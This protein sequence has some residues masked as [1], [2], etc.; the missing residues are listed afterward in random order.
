MGFGDRVSAGPL[1][2]SGHAWGEQCLRRGEPPVPISA[3]QLQNLQGRKQPQS[4]TPLGKK[5][6]CVFILLR[7]IIPSEGKRVVI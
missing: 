3:Q 5:D 2:R 1:V 6:G 7:F 4:M